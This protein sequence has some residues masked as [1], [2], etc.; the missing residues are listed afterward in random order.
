MACLRGW[1]SLLVR[2]QPLLIE[3]LMLKLRTKVQSCLSSPNH[4]LDLQLV[5]VC[6]VFYTVHLC[7]GI[8]R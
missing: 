3:K 2:P 8:L 4:S 1:N 6:L 5:D 7:A